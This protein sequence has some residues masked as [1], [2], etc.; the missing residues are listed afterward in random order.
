RPQGTAFDVGAVEACAKPAQPILVKP[1]DGKRA[2]GPAVHLDWGDVLC[3][4]K[5]KL[6]IKL[7]SPSGPLVQ[8][9]GGLTATAFTT[10]LLTKGQTYAWKVKACDA[11]YGCAASDWWTFQVK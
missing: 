10:K 11:P 1:A 6:K 5:Y 9:A 8:K 2:R 7:G 4:A 3:A